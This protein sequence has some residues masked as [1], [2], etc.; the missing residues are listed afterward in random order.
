M[1]RKPCPF[2]NESCK[3]FNRPAPPELRRQGQENGCFS[4]LDHIVPRRLG[5]TALSH[6]YI[7]NLPENKQQLCRAE[8]EEKS[9][10]GDEPLPTDEYMRERIA[11]AEALGTV[12]LTENQRRKIYGSPEAA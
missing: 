3:Y 7:Y 6:F 10:H 2:A 9:S 12:A 5:T 11:A 4:D 1:S 8:H